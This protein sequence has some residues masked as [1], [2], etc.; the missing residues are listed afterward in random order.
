GPDDDVGAAP[1]ATLLASDEP[2]AVAELQGRLSVPLSIL[3]L[4][5]LG[6]PLGKLPP[7]AGRYGRIIVG[8]LLYVVYFNLIHLATVWVETRALPAAV[9]A[10]AVHGAMLLLAIGLI[11]REQGVFVRRRRQ[12]VT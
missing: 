7:R 2:A 4:A 10:W 11:M 1:T 9:G 12:V 3:I 6:L 5:L 8:V